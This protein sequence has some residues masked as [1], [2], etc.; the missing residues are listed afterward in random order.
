M[1]GAAWE[2]GTYP[3]PYQ[4]VEIERLLQLSA[5]IRQLELGEAPARPPVREDGQ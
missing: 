4:H 1:I 5:E 3:C 2:I